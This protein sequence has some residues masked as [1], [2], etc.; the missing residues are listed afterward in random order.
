V[1]DE[2]KRHVC[3]QCSPLAEQEGIEG[4]KGGT[5]PTM[6]GNLGTL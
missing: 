5:L 1:A 6:C 4:G 2:G 3:H